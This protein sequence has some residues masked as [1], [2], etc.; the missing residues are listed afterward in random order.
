MIAAA[1][2]AGMSRC[3]VVERPHDG[4]VGLVVHTGVHTGSAR[5]MAR[6]Q[7]ELE[8][9]GEQGVEDD[10]DARRRAECLSVAGSILWP[11]F[12]RPPYQ[13]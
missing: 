13:A 1:A 3:N 9:A 8:Q 7:T 11:H 6:G 4:F 2:P 5:M 12:A 10:E